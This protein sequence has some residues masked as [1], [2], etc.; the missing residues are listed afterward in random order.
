MMNSINSQ[1]RARVVAERAAW[2][3][4][5]LARLRELPLDT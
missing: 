5:M 2:I 3:K 1:L 4:Q